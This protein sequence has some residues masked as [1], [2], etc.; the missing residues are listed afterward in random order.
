MMIGAIDLSDFENTGIIEKM[1][2]DFAQTK[3][4]RV[5]NH[6]TVSLSEQWWVVHANDLFIDDN[7][8]EEPQSEQLISLEK[9][10][11]RSNYETSS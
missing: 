11:K 6:N 9:L 4:K 5:L 1:I 10:K 8:K 7:V 3:V 2:T